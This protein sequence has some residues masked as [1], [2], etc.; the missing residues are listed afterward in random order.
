M[1]IKLGTF[2]PITLLI[3]FYYYMRIKKPS[4]S[5]LLFLAI[6]LTGVLVLFIMTQQI[7]NSSETVETEFKKESLLPSQQAVG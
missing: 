7:L 2:V 3:L 4:Y 5:T 6:L 1:L